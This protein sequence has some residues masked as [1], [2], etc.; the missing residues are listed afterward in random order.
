M[1][2]QFGFPALNTYTFMY[3]RGV[4]LVRS[5]NL[6][7]LAVH[8]GT[9]V[10][11]VTHVVGAALYMACRWRCIVPRASLALQYT[12]YVRTAVLLKKKRS[13][14][15]NRQEASRGLRAPLI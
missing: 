3:F 10:S 1:D 8:L 2:E 4:F 9:S 11:R 12:V 14:G 13:G 5:S 6:L 7:N 15:Q